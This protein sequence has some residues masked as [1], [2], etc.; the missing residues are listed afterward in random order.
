ME[1]QKHYS[2]AQI[3]VIEEDS[4]GVVVKCWA[5]NTYEVYVREANRIQNFRYNEL[6][7]YIYSKTLTPEE[8]K[9]YDWR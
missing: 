7:P 5:D 2:F 8:V 1:E 3:V 4:I 6:R 9:M